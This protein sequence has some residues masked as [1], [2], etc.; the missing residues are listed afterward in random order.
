MVGLV[1]SGLSYTLLPLTGHSLPLALAG[2]FRHLSCL[3]SS[4][5][6]LLTSLFTEILPGARATM[7]SVRPGSQRHW[8]DGRRTDWRGGVA[9]PEGWRR[10]GLVS[11]R[12][13]WPGPGLADVG[14]AWLAR[15]E[16]LL[17]P[18]L[19]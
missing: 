10:P 3:S 7:M 17:H 15:S 11:S 4:P 1:L 12:H 13:H 19:S 6:S 16:P 18:A 5:S 14:T 9:G 2:L 8:A